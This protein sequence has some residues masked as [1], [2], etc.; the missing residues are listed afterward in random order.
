MTG[1]AAVHVFMLACA[2]VAA[3]PARHLDD[4]HAALDALLPGQFSRASTVVELDLAN[5]NAMMHP[6]G[7]VCNAGWI[8]ATAGDFGFYRDG[9]RVAVSRVI[10]AIDYER[11]ALARA[12][13]VSADPFPELF[14]QLGFTATG[15]PS[16]LEAI[17]SSELIH[18]IQSPPTLDHRYLHED[19]A[20]GLVPWL[21]LAEAVDSPSQV[22]GAVVNLAGVINGVDYVNVGLT[23]DGMG[24]ANKSAAEILSH[25][26]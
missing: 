23:L 2:S 14:H 18:P 15:A 5:I 3:L 24:L 8:D 17:Q 10:E 20:W 4:C 13:G 1:P 26:S 21:H 22:I 7:M 19:V 16:V 9:T 25:V 12:L 6:P 11:I